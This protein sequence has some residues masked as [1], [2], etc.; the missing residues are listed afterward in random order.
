LTFAK[1]AS[2]PNRNTLT[3]PSQEEMDVEIKKRPSTGKSKYNLEDEPLTLQTPHTCCNR[4][5][6]A[7]M[8][9]IRRDLFNLEE[10]F[11]QAHQ[12]RKL[13][14][15]YAKVNYYLSVKFKWTK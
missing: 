12:L 7:E 2:L 14:N 13:K 6:T 9:T 4:G 1:I 11:I 8:I 5:P 3:T 15:Y 10:S